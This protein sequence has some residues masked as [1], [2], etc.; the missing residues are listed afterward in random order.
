M[1]DLTPSI[2]YIIGALI[3]AFTTFLGYSLNEYSKNR[4]NKDKRLFARQM[5]KFEID[6]NRQLLEEFYREIK[7]AAEI[8][9]RSLGY[10]MGDLSFPPVDNTAFNKYSYLLSDSKENKFEKIYNF[11]RIIGDLEIIHSKTAKISHKSY[12]PRYSKLRTHVLT[13]MP[14]DTGEGEY[15]TQFIELWREFEVDICSLI[16]SNPII[17]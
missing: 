8:N 3:G 9:G 5:I 2:P 12:K 7:D 17:L 1:I 14:G 11:Y 16:K 13:L 6:R 10:N 4:E 15:S